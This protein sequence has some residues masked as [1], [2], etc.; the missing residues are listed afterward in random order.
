MIILARTYHEQ[1]IELS[2]RG[3]TTQALNLT[4]D[5]PKPLAEVD[6]GIS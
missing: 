3:N 1:S 6:S 5:E 2:S 4:E